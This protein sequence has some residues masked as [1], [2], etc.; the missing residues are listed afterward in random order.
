MLIDEARALDVEHGDLIDVDAVRTL[1]D[2]VAVA[3]ERAVEHA[4]R[5]ARTGRGEDAFLIVEKP[6]VEDGQIAPL[7]AYPGTVVERGVGAGESDAANGEVI[8]DRHEDALV[9]ADLVTQ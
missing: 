1:R 9:L 2:A 6:A 5:A 7:G 8:A 4:D 3:A